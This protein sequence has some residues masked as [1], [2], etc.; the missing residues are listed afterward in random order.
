MQ[1][2]PVQLLGLL[3][4]ITFL[5]I[6]WGLYLQIRANWKANRFAPGLAKGKLVGNW[7]RYFL[8]SLWASSKTPFDL[9]MLMARVPAVLL[10]AVLLMQ[11][12]RSRPRRK[13]LFLAILLS[14]IVLMVGC[15]L[16]FRFASPAIAMIFDALV[17]INFASV[18]FVALP[19]E[20]Q[21]ISRVGTGGMSLAL[22]VAY[23]SNYSCWFLYGL[24]TKEPVLI[25][26]FCLAALLSWIVV[27]EFNPPIRSWFRRRLQNDRVKA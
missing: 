18:I 5:T 14:S 16:A 13:E 2:T 15:G 17:T 1:V 12:F 11:I 23:A 7:I 9:F 25:V 10:S 22:Q 27:A 3:G 4:N 26:C 20:I 8:W 19:R 21:Q 6:H 24:V